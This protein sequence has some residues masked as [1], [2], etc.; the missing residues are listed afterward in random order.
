MRE[1]LGVRGG[2][3][4]DESVRRTFLRDLRRRGLKEVRLFVGA[5][6]ELLVRDVTAEFPA[7][8]LQV[9]I[10]QLERAVLALV[11]GPE[12]H[13]AS[14]A[15]AALRL[16]PDAGV[17]AEKIRQM[18]ERLDRTN[19]AEASALLG[20]MLPHAFS[21]RPFPRSQW[22]QISTTD[23][24]RRAVKPMRERIRQIGPVEDI[25]AL[26]LLAAAHLRHVSRTVW[27]QRRYLRPKPRGKAGE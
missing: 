25:H 12:L 20:R 11:P 23:A 17:S 22:S 3:A 4:A 13:A 27:G 26:V 15:L 7:V 9:C 2:E 19:L 6:D 1:V 5:M 24:I 10:A 21:Y 16:S 8:R 14:L 18:Q